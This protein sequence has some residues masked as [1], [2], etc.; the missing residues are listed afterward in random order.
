MESTENTKKE[1]YKIMATHKTLECK[2]PS[3]P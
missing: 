2:S 1:T 3:K